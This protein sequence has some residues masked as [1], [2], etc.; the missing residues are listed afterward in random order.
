MQRCLLK[1]TTTKPDALRSRTMRAVKSKNTTPEMVV[2][3]V[4]YRSG[5]RYRLHRS[6]LPGSP[7]I[8]FP[9]R[10][11]VVFVHGCWWHGHCC[12]RGARV[13]VKNRD[14][15]TRKVERNRS[16]DTDALRQL[17]DLGW[18]ADVVW[19]CE[20]KDLSA[21]QQRLDEFLRK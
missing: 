20:L 21:L 7:D 12:S 14:Y 13:P 9:G 6:D 5:L 16:R 17:A 4:L 18:T 2:R 11:K 19:E 1:M 15:W 8:V 10:R 3:R